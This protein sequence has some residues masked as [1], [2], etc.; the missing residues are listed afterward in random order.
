[1][2]F[3]IAQNLLKLLV[4][5]SRELYLKKDPYTVA[6]GV[7]ENS[8]ALAYYNYINNKVICVKYVDGSTEPLRKTD[9]Y[10]FYTLYLVKSSQEA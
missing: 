8:V 10:S 1:M 9:L 6:I 7:Y 5:K 4:N 2:V 3:L